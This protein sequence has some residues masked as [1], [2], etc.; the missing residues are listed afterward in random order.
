MISRDPASFRDPSG[1]IFI[2]DRIFY[3]LVSYVYREDYRRLMDSGLYQVLVEQNLL[4]NHT[5]TKLSG[6]FPNKYKILKPRQ[7]QFITYPY[8][9]CAS[10]LKDAALLTLRVQDLALK[11]GMTLKDASAYNIQFEGCRPVFIDTLSFTR[12]A[13][14]PWAGYAQFCRH[15]LYPLILMC[16]KDVRLAKL[17]LAFVD[18]IPL[19]LMFNL[20]P[21][22]AYVNNRILFHFLTN[23]LSEKLSKYIHPATLQKHGQHITKQT[24]SALSQSL[25]KIIT[26]LPTPKPTSFW[27]SYKKTDSY[28]SSAVKAKDQIVRRILTQLKPK[29]VWDV[30]ANNGYYSNL[31]ALA[32]AQVLSIDSDHGAL[33]ALYRNTELKS[34]QITTLWTDLAN[35]S[36]ALG[37]GHSERASLVARRSADLTIVL[38]LIHHLAIGNNVSLEAVAQFFQKISKNV[39]IE[40]IPKEDKQVKQLLTLR[41][42][43]FSDYTKEGF[44][45][46][47][48]KYFQFVR[49]YPVAGSERIIYFLKSK[50]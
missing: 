17:L 41:E 28:T 47:F 33:E 36:P 45:F 40:F 1:Y 2:R 42:D 19:D 34:D 27:S 6:T 3:R 22:R 39:L 31:V 20:I 46:A 5:E 21:K 9:W 8:E 43:I 10:Q 4:V 38:A 13:H 14:G 49:S 32:G 50:K 48:G 11:Y 24:L 44:A 30:G 18:G 37:W 29:V 15:F 16:Y 23:G 26:S 25:K 35:P 7:L 12:Y